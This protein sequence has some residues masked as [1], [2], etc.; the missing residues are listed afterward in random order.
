VP[1]A[2]QTPQN[3]NLNHDLRVSSDGKM[4]V[5]DTGNATPYNSNQY[6]ELY[7]APE[8]F[9]ASQQAL[10]AA[11]SGV[12]LTQTGTTIRGKPPGNHFKRTLHLV[13]IGF[14]DTANNASY[15]GCNA[16]AWNVMGTVRNA[17]PTA[18]VANGVFR[19]KI[20]GSHLV[21]A[22]ADDGAAFKAVR[23]AITGQN[24]SGQARQDWQQLGAN[25]RKKAEKKYGINQYAK[26]RAAEAISI[27]TAGTDGNGGMGHHAGILARSG[28]DYITLENYAGNP[29]TVLFGKVSVNPNWYVRMFGGKTGQSFYEFHKTYEAADYGTH[30]IAVRSRAV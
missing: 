16:N 2:A 26:P 10:N 28:S 4:A 14:T 11:G 18:T 24:A 23:T 25:E 5:R 3:Y 6:Q 1:V 12:T 13:T 15:A 30:P 7:L 17:Q 20:N 29:G 27:F 9:T 21:A 8:V 19:A 22:Q